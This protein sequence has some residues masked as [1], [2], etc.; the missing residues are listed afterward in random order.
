MNNNGDDNN[1][2][3]AWG[4]DEEGWMEEIPFLGGGGGGIAAAVNT[5]HCHRNAEDRRCSRCGA[6]GNEAKRAAVLRHSKGIQLWYMS[7]KVKDKSTRKVK[8][9]FSFWAK[10]LVTRDASPDMCQYPLPTSILSHNC[11]PAW[12]HLTSTVDV[13][14]PMVELLD[15]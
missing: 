2:W 3:P 13:A 5:V 14:L 1:A 8:Q 10:L 7:K 4:L 6:D 11:Q 15:G 12:Q 9:S